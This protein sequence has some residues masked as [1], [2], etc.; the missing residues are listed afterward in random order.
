MNISHM[1]VSRHSVIELC[2]QQYKYK[3]HLKTESLE[4]EPFYFIYGKI[5]HKIAE[6][7][8]LNKGEKPLSEITKSVLSGEIVLEESNGQPVYAPFLPDSYRN[9]LGEH[10]RNLKKLTDQLGYD[11]YA[12]YDF[13]YD[14]D[15]PNKKNLVGFIDRLFQRGDNWYVIDYKTTQRGPYRK[16]EKTVLSD[17]QLRCYAKVVQKNFNVKAENIKTALYYVE[18]GNLIGA[19][20]TQDNLD[21]AEVEL[22]KA[23]LHIESKN[24]NTVTGNVGEHCSRCNWRKICPF[25][26]ATKNYEKSNSSY[27]S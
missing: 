16:N 25:Y 5:F 24:E 21:S 22:R 13:E 11:G 1:S 19:S 18:G 10:L 20:F 27:F 14:L 7:Y 2:E 26:Q 3:Y 15:Y 23:Y 9:R 12:E 17:L 8:V 4:P 6:E